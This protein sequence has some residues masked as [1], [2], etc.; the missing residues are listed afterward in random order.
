MSSDN[1]DHILHLNGRIPPLKP[2]QFDVCLYH[3]NCPDGIGGAYPFWK[4]NNLLGGDDMCNPGIVLWGVKYNE[5]YP[6]DLIRGK[7]VVIVD[8]CYSRSEILEMCSIAQSILILDHH[9]TAKRELENLLALNELSYIF[10][11]KRSGAQIAWDYCDQVVRKFGKPT[12]PG[13][14]PS[15]SRPW[16]IEVIADRDLWKWEYPSSKELGKALYHGGWYKWEKMYELEKGEIYPETFLAEGRTLI[17]LEEKEIDYVSATSVLAEFHGHRVRVVTCNPNIRSE[18]GNKVANMDD[19]EFAVI[20][21]YDFASDQWWVS[22]RGSENCTIPLNQL[23]ETYS[24]GGHLKAC[25]FA[26]H[27]V[28][29]PEWRNADTTTRQKLAHGTLWDYFKVL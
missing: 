22:L 17:A 29:S 15:L 13:V 27:G 11:M 5:P 6:A 10:D 7:H 21:R 20:W 12:L 3:S 28:N 26:I 14:E 18:A 24:G 4:A 19:C 9:D 8:F 1:Q 25:G 16:F 2:T 23:C